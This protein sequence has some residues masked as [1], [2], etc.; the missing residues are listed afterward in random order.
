LPVTTHPG[1]PGYPAN[2]T[3]LGDAGNAA[4]RPL[5]GENTAE[6]LAELKAIEQS[7]HNQQAKDSTDEPRAH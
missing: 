3:F 2:G 7:P 6:V 5:I 4:P 1:R